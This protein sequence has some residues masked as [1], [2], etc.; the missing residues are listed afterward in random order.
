MTM[1]T[2]DNNSQVLLLVPEGGTFECLL[3][4]FAL[5]F[6]LGLPIH[7]PSEPNN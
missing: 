2:R 4:L 3:D 1:D 5:S 7:L 6:S